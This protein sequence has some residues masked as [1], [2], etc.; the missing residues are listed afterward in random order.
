[1]SIKKHYKGNCTYLS[2]PKIFDFKLCLTRR[3]DRKNGTPSEARRV[4]IYNIVMKIN[5]YT[6]A[7]DNYQ[8]GKILWHRNEDKCLHGPRLMRLI[9][10]DQENF[11]CDHKIMILYLANQTV[12]CL[13][14]MIMMFYLCDSQSHAK[15]NGGLKGEECSFIINHLTFCVR[16]K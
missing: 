14:I 6:L 3:T 13:S 10:I 15:N 11:S 12:S 2:T 1:M 8:W 4:I 9:N 16:G 5:V 7:T